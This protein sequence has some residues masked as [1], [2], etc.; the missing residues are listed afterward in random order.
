MYDTPIMM[1]PVITIV[2]GGPAGLTL[3]CLLGQAGIETLVLDNQPLEIGK[4]RNDGRTAAL[5]R[6]SVGVL[7]RAGVN[8]EDLP[9]TAPLKTLRLVDL[10]AG[11]RDPLRI[12]FQSSEID[13]PYFGLNIRND[14]LHLALLHAVAKYPSVTLKSPVTIDTYTINGA[15]ITLH[16]DAGKI[17]TSLVAAADGKSS[18]MRDLAGIETQLTDYHQSAIT[19]MIEHE[20]PHN[21]TSTEFHRPGGPFTL[22]PLSGNR[23]SIVWMEETDRANDIVNLTPEKFARACQIETNDELGKITVINKPQ[24]WPIHLL[25]AKSLTAPRIALVAEAA[26]ALPPSG[27]QGLNLS[28]RDVDALANLIIDAAQLGLDTG[29]PTLLNKYA[30]ARRG[31]INSRATAVDGLNRLI[32]SDSRMVRFARRQGLLMAASLQPLRRAAM[33]F[34]WASA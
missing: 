27:A 28:L 2:G 6:P 19:C 12:D 10:P 32:L 21:E 33:R 15:G 24:C 11:G 4:R 3:A 17:Q 23:S 34:G 29:S 18:R 14:E 20:K 25:Q 13:E 5:L 16:T 31:D 1:T 8:P 9:D 30:N 7:Q 22:V 26:H